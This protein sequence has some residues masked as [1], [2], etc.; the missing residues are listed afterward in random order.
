M[1]FSQLW[2]LEVQ[3]QDVSMVLL[4]AGWS[5]TEVFQVED[6]ETPWQQWRVAQWTDSRNIFLKI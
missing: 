1:Y 6:I 5:D 2:R 4:A 3:D